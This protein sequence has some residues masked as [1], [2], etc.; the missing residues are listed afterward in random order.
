MNAD[1][2]P[3]TKS[4]WPILRVKLPAEKM[5]LNRN[6]Q[7]SWASQ[8][9][10]MSELSG[11]PPPAKGKSP[12][13][14]MHSYIWSILLQIYRRSKHPRLYGIQTFLPLCRRHFELQQFAQK[15]KTCKNKIVMHRWLP[16]V[17]AKLR[18]TQ[19][20]EGD[21]RQLQFSHVSFS[22]CFFIF[23]QMKTATALATIA[24]HCHCCRKC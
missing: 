7:A 12:V 15:F 11:R 1:S 23:Y 4:I 8:P 16:R 2:M 19:L 20:W 5:G 21:E 17:F 14:K 3:K 24:A 22:T 13:Y 10:P 18:Y 6:F 9:T